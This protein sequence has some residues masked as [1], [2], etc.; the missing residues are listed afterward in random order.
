MKFNLFYFFFR[1][2][3]DLVKGI[4]ADNPWW[5]LI[6][7]NFLLPTRWGLSVWRLLRIHFR[8]PLQSCWLMFLID[9]FDRTHPTGWKQSWQVS[10]FFNTWMKT[11]STILMKKKKKLAV[12]TRIQAELIDGRKQSIITITYMIFKL[13]KMNL[14]FQMLSKSSLHCWWIHP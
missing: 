1:L 7:L 3:A 8:G 11:N 9:G 14:V 10:L 5:H 12:Q 13:F 4:M 2:L 6:P